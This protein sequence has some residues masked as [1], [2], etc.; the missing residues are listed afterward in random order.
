MVSQLSGEASGADGVSL[1]NRDGVDLRLLSALAARLAR[2]VRPG[3]LVLLHGPLGAGKTTFVRLLARGL[4]VTDQVRSPSFTI[5][6]VYAGPIP[7]NHLD[8]YRLEGFDDEDVLALE[9]YVS[10]EVVTLVE[11]PEAGMS[12]LGAAAWTVR[13]DHESLETRRFRL[14]ACDAEVAARWEAAR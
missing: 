9:E 5:A 11:W 13:L 7:V 8:L 4:G 14:A 2:A 12:R 1:L 6:N 3:D 10:P